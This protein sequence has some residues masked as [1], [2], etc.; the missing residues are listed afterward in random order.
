MSRA[1]EPVAIVGMGCVLPDAFDADAFARNVSAGHS[2]IRDLSRGRWSWKDYL[3]PKNGFDATHSIRGAAIEDYAFDW[4]RFRIPPADA[5]LVNAMQLRTLDAGVQALSAVKSIPRETTGV[6]LGGTGL[7][8]QPDSGIRIRLNEILESLERSPL[9]A[10]LDEARRARVISEVRARVDRRFGPVSEDNVV[11]ASVSVAAG[12]IH[13]HFDLKGPHFSVDAGFASSLASVDVGVRMLRD[14]TLDCAV[15]GGVSE[16]LTPL[17]VVAFARLGGLAR[18]DVRPFDMGA[19]GT[20]LGEGVVVFALKR[21]DD[22]VRDGDS[23]VALVRGVGGAS[24]GRGKSLVAPNPDGQALAMRRAL[25]DADIDPGTVGFVECHA[26]GTPV[27]DASEIEAIGRVYGR[28]ERPL[29]LGSAKPF[30]GHLRGAAGA[31]GMLRAVQALT[32]GLVPAQIG[33]E[34]A[35][36][37]VLPES[38]PLRVPRTATELG[39]VGGADLRRAAVSAFGFGGIGYHVVLEE[40]RADAKSLASLRWRRAPVP[41]PIAIVGMGGVF[42]GGENVPAFFESLVQGRDSTREVPRERWDVDRYFDEDRDRNETCYT[43]LG[44]FLDAL[45]RPEPRWHIPPVSLERVDPGQLLVLRATEEAIADAGVDMERLD[46]DRVG[47]HLA[48]LPYQGKKFLA[49]IR[50]NVREVAH[51]MGLALREASVSPTKA[52]AILDEA[53]AR[54]RASL[55]E[56]TEDTMPGYLGS[57][58]AARVTRLFDLHGPHFV[59]DSACASSHAALMSSVQALR[60]GLCDVALSGGVW[61]DMKP[62]FFVAACRFQ[63]LSATGSTPFAAEADGF[64]PGEG[65][66]MVVLMRLSDAVAK[67]LRVRAILRSVAGASDGKGRSVLAPNPVGEATAMARAIRAAELE[68]GEVDYVE[69][70]GTGTAL[71]DVV[72]VD[73]VARAYSGGRERPMLIGSVKSNIGHLNAAAGIVGLIKTVCSIERGI[74]PASLKARN[75]NPSIDF[76]KSEIEVVHENR[77]WPDH[78]DRPRRAGV[79]GFGVGGTNMHMIVEQHRP[80]HVSAVAQPARATAARTETVSALSVVPIAIAAEA[81]IESAFAAI[82]AI[83]ADADTPYLEAVAA[84]QSKTSHHTSGVR[85]AIVARSREELA[86]RLALLERSSAPF[87]HGRALAA[88]GIFVARIGRERRVALMFPGQG[89]QYPNMLRE[90]M[91]AFPEIRETIDEADRIYLRIAGRPLSPSFLVDDADHYEQRDE[92]IHC[93]VFVVGCAMAR[94]LS[95]RGLRFDAV[96]GQSAGELAALV[97]SGVLS[98]ED[99]LSAM[100]TRT[101]SVLAIPTRDAGQ[102]VALPCGAA[103]ARELI[104]GLPGYAAL[105][106]DNSPS[107]SIVSVDRAAGDALAKRLQET[108]VEGTVLAVSHGYHSELI[109]AA[110]PAYRA[111]LD[112]L[113]YHPPRVTVVSTITGAAIEDFRPVALATALERQYVEPVRLRESIEALYDAGVRTFIECGP[114][115]PLSNFVS[116]ILGT[117]E[118][119]AH[120]TIHP[121]VGE[122]EQL[123]RTMACAF[124]HGAM[125]RFDRIAVRPS[126]TPAV[127]EV[128]GSKGSVPMPTHAK[129]EVRV[130]AAFAR[131]DPSD[132]ATGDRSTTREAAFRQDVVALMRTLSSNIDAFVAKWGDEAVDPA[133]ESVVEMVRP[134]AVSMVAVDAPVV[135][136]RPPRAAVTNADV[137]KVFS[138]KLAARTGYPLDMLEADLD[139]EADLGIDTV[140]QIAVMGETREHFGLPVDAGFKLRHYPTIAA[141]S[142]YLVKRMGVDRPVSVP[143]RASSASQ[144]P[145][146]VSVVPAGPSYAEVR[147]VFVEKLVAKTGYPA[148]MLEDDLDLEADLGIDT[149]KQISVMGETRERFGLAVDPRFKLRHYP[150][151]RAFCT[152]LLERMS[153]AGPVGGPPRGGAG[154]DRTSAGPANGASLASAAATAAATDEVVRVPDWMLELRDGREGWRRIR[155][156]AD[157]SLVSIVRSMPHLVLARAPRFDEIVA[158]A[159][160]PAEAT[161]EALSALVYD[162][163]VEASRLLHVACTG[164]LADPQRVESWTILSLPRPGSRFGV[165]AKLRS[166]GRIAVECIADDGRRLAR[167]EGVVI[168]HDEHG[169]SVVSEPVVL[170]RRA[171]LK[172]RRELTPSLEHEAS[173]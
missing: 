171:W 99:A 163:M 137:R 54:F 23:I 59:V 124:V 133:F 62:E 144:R 40:Y 169:E 37:E 83:I 29:W 149:V 121:K 172:L 115:W 93:A 1:G 82:Q 120:A 127:Q 109:A 10:E 118:H 98:F 12:R 89:S 51:E 112:R 6:I 125:H 87:E 64:V 24:D 131:N 158:R 65:G 123:L 122:T 130:E 119:V 69:C 111:M 21:L 52:D 162:A 85:I 25:E 152:Y 48:F 117:R 141:F 104:A 3:E 5:E 43:K 9:F 38:S 45:P 28:S 147:D 44:C 92:D 134:A 96:V 164:Q 168:G 103:E 80:M 129:S 11:N 153:G 53:M 138:E 160:A 140:K 128:Q 41:E 116:E 101:T 155:E 106:A 17:E 113:A 105:A 81:S 4:R 148:D 22:A 58:N 95:D 150:T 76:A 16:L 142:D 75:P 68:A 56:I 110:R 135:Q 19:T 108:K 91:A 145:Q 55:P 132:A 73:A 143:P 27:G 31:V 61:C 32:S 136:S 7:G 14:H 67:G 66:G 72:E 84:S 165:R 26:T 156:S 97:V 79:S 86:R 57:V 170:E 154:G 2:A 146:R 78:P 74:I 8:W 151:I 42:P 70:H 13:M 36:P 88:Q 47:V 161:Q 102:M 114:K 157:P 167:A 126:P 20:L 33:F 107:S 77:P 166:V 30:V 90:A 15:V 50:V 60:H 39:R 100:R 63:A 139:L 94:F 71:G 18:E 49:D 46:R 159:E 173:L 34:R 35:C